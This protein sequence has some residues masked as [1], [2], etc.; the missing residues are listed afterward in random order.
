MTFV[1][2]FEQLCQR[3]IMLTTTNKIFFETVWNCVIF[4]CVGIKYVIHTFTGVG[5]L[6]YNK[7]VTLFIRNNFLSSGSATPGPCKCTNSA[8]Q[9]CGGDNKRCILNV[10]IKDHGHTSQQDSCL[11]I[12]HAV[13]TNNFYLLFAHVCHIAKVWYWEKKGKVLRSREK[14]EI[15]IHNSRVLQRTTG[16]KRDDNAGG[17]EYIFRTTR[18]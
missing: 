13:V 4:L 3:N 12:Y 14:K 5:N 6:S 11:R 9:G 1:W 2:L 16:T 17:E 15:W 10:F 7:I 18:S 8:C